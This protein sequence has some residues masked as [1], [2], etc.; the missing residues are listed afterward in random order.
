[1]TF[2]LDDTRF[3]R[4]FLFSL[5]QNGSVN[6]I[7]TV[8]GPL[9]ARRVA[10]SLPAPPGRACPQGR[11]AALSASLRARSLDTQAPRDSRRRSSTRSRNLCW[12]VRPPR[13]LWR[14]LQRSRQIAHMVARRTRSSGG[15]RK[16]LAREG[17]C[18]RLRGRRRDAGRLADRVSANQGERKRGLLPHQACGTPGY[19]MPQSA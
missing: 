15:R 5:P 12:R 3:P 17:I 6:G 1:M 2:P 9:R 8:F 10:N 7:I 4:V 13:R 18:V 11:P 14:R 19:R 16:S